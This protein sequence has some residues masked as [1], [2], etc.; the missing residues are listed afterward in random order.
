MRWQVEA[1]DAKTGEETRL[2]IEALTE[3]EAERLA[4]YN[5]LLVSRVWKAGAPAAPVVAYATPQAAEVAAGAAPLEYLLLTR[6]A[7]ATRTLGGITSALGWIALIGGVGLFGY[8][9]VRNGWADWKDW[10]AWLPPAAAVAWPVALGGAVAVVA[11][12]TLRLLAAAALALVVGQRFG[13]P[14]ERQ[15][16]ADGGAVANAGVPFMQ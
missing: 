2:T 5:G 1:A 9:A 10:R 12:S 16:R 13:P 6:R 15:A 8:V 14:G 3:V 11:G 7:R 4:R